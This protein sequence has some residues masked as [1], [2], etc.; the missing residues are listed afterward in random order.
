M[1]CIRRATDPLHAVFG[2]PELPCGVVGLKDKVTAGAAAFLWVGHGCDAIGV[3]MVSV[4]SFLQSLALC[5]IPLRTIFLGGAR[6]ASIKKQELP[7]VRGE[8]ILFK[9]GIYLISINRFYSG[10]RAGVID[11]KNGFSTG[12][13][14]AGCLL[15]TLVLGANPCHAYRVKKVCEEV[16]AR[17]GKS[18]KCRTV[19][20]TS[21]PEVKAP[22]KKEDEKKKKGG[23]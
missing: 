12:G 2:H 23:H 11:L 22:E 16:Q 5:L 18:E 8:I 9:I 15:V 6:H 14:L 10:V 20:D 4:R 1:S 19:L 7:A 13:L 17:Q 3:T 21:D